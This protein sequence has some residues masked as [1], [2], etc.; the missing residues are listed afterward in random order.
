MDGEGRKTM[1]H[2]RSWRA[3]LLS[4]ILERTI[5]MGGHWTENLAKRKL[6]E[7]AAALIISSVQV[8]VPGEN[9]TA[10]ATWSPHHRLLL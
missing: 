3:Y 6:L 7:K 2:R 10:K 1:K 9:Q 4:S 8:Q 5:A